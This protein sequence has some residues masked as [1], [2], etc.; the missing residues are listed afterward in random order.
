MNA[1]AARYL[2]AAALC[3][4]LAACGDDAAAPPAQRMVKGVVMKGAVQGATVKFFVMDAAGNPL[5]PASPV[6]TV[7]TGA[8]G[9]FSAPLPNQGVHLLA[10]TFDGA[11]ADESDPATGPTRRRIALPASPNVGFEAVL[12]PNVTS[13]AI[14]PYSSALLKKARLQA[15]GANFFNVFDAVRA[16]A[17]QAFG[18]DPI[19]TIPADPLSPSDV[20]TQAAR[21]YGL[22][23][24][25]AS[26]AINTIATSAGHLP[27]FADV[28][29]FIDD[30]GSDGIFDLVSIPDEIRRFR[31]NNFQIYAGVPLPTINETLL[32][33]PATVPNAR[34]IAVADTILV[35]EGSTAT[36]LS[37][38]SS[39]V[40][41]NDTDAEGSTLTAALAGGPSDGNLTLNTDG[42]F[43][44]IHDGGEGSSDSFTYV[45]NDGTINSL[46]ASV[47]ITVSAVNDAPD[48]VDD[49]NYAGQAGGTVTAMAG[50]G[51]VRDNDTDAD[52]TNA[53]LSVTTTPLSGPSFAASFSLAADGT[54]SYQ[55]DGS[56]NLVD[57]FTYEVCD[58]AGPSQLCDTAVA[59]ITL[60]AGGGT[61]SLLP[62]FTN[63]GDLKLLD[64]GAVID[65][66]NN[67]L[68]IESGLPTTG[69]VART[70]QRASINAG[71]AT[72]I[73]AARLIY[74]KDN[75]STRTVWKVNLEAGQSHAPVQVSNITDAC[76]INGLAED[77]PTPDNSIIRIDTAGTNGL[78]EDGSGDD[79]TTAEAWL[80]PL[81]TGAGA[82]GTQIG[83]GHC[84]G[85]T[86]IT[87][88]GGALVGVLATE[89]D[90][91]GSTFQLTRR[92]LGNLNSPIGITTL[93]IAGQGQIYAH[94][95]R[96]LGDQHSYIRA[97][98][99]AD[100]SYKLHRFN[101][102]TNTLTPVFDYATADAATFVGDFDASTFDA[103]NFYFTS[104]DGIALIKV[105]HAATAEGQTT[106]LVVG[107]P[108]EQ[109]VQVR[110][111]PTR[112]V[113]QVAGL[114]GGVFTIPKAGGTA[115]A[116]AQNSASPTLVR[117]AITNAERVFIDKVSGT[118]APVY[119]AFAIDSD[120]ANA[121]ADVADA[122]WAGGS[123]LDSCNF[124]LS[125]EDT[126][127]VQALYL[128]RDASTSSALLELANAATGV[129][130]GNVVGTIFNVM[131]GASV[132]GSGFGRYTQFT[133]FAQVGQ[134]DLFLGD[135]QLAGASPPAQALVAVANAPS[136]DNFWLLFGTDEGGGGGGGSQDPDADGLTNAQ[137][138]ALGTNP[139]DFD[140][141]DDGLGDG[142]EV[143]TYSTSPLVAD[144]DGDGLGDG[145]EVLSVGTNP[146]NPDTDGDAVSDQIEVEAFTDAI[147]T[148]DTVIYVDQNAGCTAA[149]DG[150]SW[151]TAW[152]DETFVS[153]A[154]N[155]SGSSP[156]TTKFVFFAGGT[157]GPLDLTG[158]DR[159]HVYYVGSL[160]PG[161]VIPAFPPTTTF[162]GGGSTAA[163]SIT[164]SDQV[165]LANVAFSSGFDPV[166]GGG[167][168][169]GPPAHTASLQNS[170][171]LR[172]VHISGNISAV[173][174]GGAVVEGNTSSLFI[175]E[176]EIFGNQAQGNTGTSA[177]GGGLLAFNG[178]HL[179]ISKSTV[180][181]NTVSCANPSCFAFG[182]GISITGG[183]T[184]L[185]ILD[186]IVENNGTATNAGAAAVGGGIGVDSSAALTMNNTEVRHNTAI[187]AAAA[188]A[189]GGG[190]GGTGADLQI[191]G[192]VIKGNSSSG[193]IVAP[194]LGGGGGI[195]MDAGSTLDMS[196]TIV[197][198]NKA[199]AGPGGGINYVDS[200]F[201]LIED[202]KFLSNS[203]LNPGGGLHIH[204]QGLTSVFNN[205]F[206]GNVATDSVAEG[207]AMELD[208]ETGNPTLSF[209][210]NTVAYN[211][212]PASSAVGGGISVKS[213][214][215][216]TLSANNNNIW[217]NQ[218]ISQTAN[219]GDNYQVSGALTVNLSGDNIDEAGLAGNIRLNPAFVQG[220]YLD[221]I[222]P[223]ASIN[224]GNN[225]FAGPVVSP[226]YTTNPNGTADSSSP[227]VDIGFHHQS[228]SAGSFVAVS[229]ESQN[230]GES[231]IRPAFANAPS[232]EPGHLITVHPQAAV[233]L[234][235]LTTI[236]PAGPG[237]VIAWDRGDGSY[238]FLVSGVGGPVD[239]EIYAD[240]QPTARIISLFV[241][242]GC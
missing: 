52:N 225:T 18:F 21:Q 98:L 115:M 219:A 44:F 99:V 127:G 72:N 22:L 28:M 209:D 40:L 242:N 222:L 80:V 224:T 215:P 19:T 156:G 2:L 122:Q 130:T 174:G 36:V 123:F 207:G 170:V 117:L 110:P 227:A 37:D 68:T 154:N 210:S 35:S 70:L 237:D 137:E 96:G 83:L 198:D 180:S 116:L 226:P 55:H 34:P 228:A 176:S 88:A 31:N 221:P 162:S 133:A 45:A 64:P 129:P 86:G 95:Q 168:R 1:R 177:R 175:S 145:V 204:P 214:P 151:A 66:V 155:V 26:Q 202:S 146:L 7:T 159:Q 113:Y 205:L 236:D 29:L 241:P 61:D 93:D 163:A 167:L 208:V 75:G 132:F 173:D 50:A 8:D 107:S 89:D 185:F 213:T 149:C 193:G 51:G 172:R 141:D 109:I 171:N 67:P 211:Q 231:I 216:A 91:T 206:V 24:G 5:D 199:D 12:P 3:G 153:G 181:G 62:L 32:S 20:A 126:I 179:D 235:S 77:L 41:D 47:S 111:T 189:G 65:G 124:N 112:L 53:E 38:G 49:P 25:A 58:L 101:V 150:T 178:G 114:S 79:F 152:P 78:C 217:F 160:Q 125:C 60:S 73:R 169:L 4:L 102:A 128:R 16:Q 48:A 139:N 13:F 182:G 161:F 97:K 82:P 81:S 166:L 42:T 232:G 85:I 142:D 6:A 183:G 57:S 131:S 54:F 188:Q 164:Q 118:A 201:V 157:Y 158:S 239:F 23:L 104:G 203:S 87:S 147:A 135:S 238:A 143:N 74:I 108:G 92:D 233:S 218:D 194:P 33:Q 71:V 14:T 46:P 90:G 212:T 105:A 240:E 43:S 134:S 94:M 17:T 191:D 230:C 148:I 121:S 30:L 144:S 15:S 195:Y 136:G 84:C 187:A 9:T 76:R 200:G 103:T 120:G 138:A 229:D 190:I 100:A 59:T 223:S 63:A 27:D 140:T 56:A 192:S 184:S 220:F 10:Q 11:Y 119:T 106:N 196:N 69:F 165:K 186:S 197:A 234:G 39:S